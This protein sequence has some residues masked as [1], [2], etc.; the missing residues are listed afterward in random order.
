APASVIPS[1]FVLERHAPALCSRCGAAYETAGCKGCPG[2][3]ILISACMP[4]PSLRRNEATRPPQFTLSPS[5]H[6]GVA[7][8]AIG[9]ARRVRFWLALRGS[10]PGR[11]VLPVIC[12]G[13][14]VWRIDLFNLRL[15][16]L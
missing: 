5:R 8:V 11:R 13:P 1:G 14:P 15:Q 16:R 10:P 6:S 2:G 7:R 4:S 12:L 3:M 9:D